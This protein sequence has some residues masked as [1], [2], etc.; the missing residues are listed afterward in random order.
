MSA[1][2]QVLVISYDLDEPGQKYA[3]L[4]TLIKG[5]GT[6]ARFGGSAYLVATTDAPT[7]VRNHLRQALDANDKLYVGAAPRPAAW[8]GLPDEVGNWIRENQA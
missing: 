3:R 2:K 8:V 5:Y 4:L 6:W 1:N 7:E